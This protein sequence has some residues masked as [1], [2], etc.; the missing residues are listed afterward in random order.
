MIHCLSYDVFI[1]TL[2]MDFLNKVAVNK[3]CRQSVLNSENIVFFGSVIQKFQR[4]KIMTMAIV[5][6]KIQSFRMTF[7]SYD[8]FH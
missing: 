6:E 8:L 2:D 7:I 3:E 5:Y 4:L 1:K